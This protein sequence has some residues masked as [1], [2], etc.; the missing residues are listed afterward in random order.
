MKS[1]CH[2]LRHTESVTKVHLANLGPC[3]TRFAS[4]LNVQSRA[5]TH[6]ASLAALVSRLRYPEPLPLGRLE[7]CRTGKSLFRNRTDQF[8][9]D[10]LVAT[11]GGKSV[12]ANGPTTVTHGTDD[13]FAGVKSDKFVLHQLCRGGRATGVLRIS[14]GSPEIQRNLSDLFCHDIHMF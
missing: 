1:F 7:R 8:S 4:L 3:Y 2:T 13:V 6:R 9:I 14:S 12:T 10:C 5:E 11:A